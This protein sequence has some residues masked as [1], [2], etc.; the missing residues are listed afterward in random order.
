MPVEDVPDGVVTTTSTV[1]VPAGDVAV[2]DESEFTVKVVAAAD[3]NLTE[4]APVN[5][6]PITLTTVPPAAGPAFGETPETTV[7]YM[8]LS[9]ALVVEVPP[10]VV[11]VMS[12]VPA[13]PAGDTAVIDE[14]LT[15]AYELAA[16]VPNMTLLA[17]MN[18]VPVI[19]T[20]VPPA[21]LPVDGEIAVTVGAYVN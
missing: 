9:A 4:V 16:V 21:V 2:I 12:T 7:A 5:P 6:L 8:N 19:V 17:P 3:P 13:E 14:A 1:P 18:P 20:D 10:I 15:T 11:T